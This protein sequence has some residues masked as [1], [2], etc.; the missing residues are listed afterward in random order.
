MVFQKNILSVKSNIKNENEKNRN[1]LANIEVLNER[2]SDM[3]NEISDLNSQISHY[4]KLD[5][6]D[7]AKF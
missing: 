5:G 3:D 2:I 1:V 6:T 7:E 4:K